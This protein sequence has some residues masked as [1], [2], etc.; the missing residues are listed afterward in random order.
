MYVERTSKTRRNCVILLGSL[1][2]LQAVQ[3]QAVAQVSN[4]LPPATPVAP[5]PVLSV[6]PNTGGST[7]DQLRATKSDSLELQFASG[8]SCRTGGGDTPSLVLYGDSGS[9]VAPIT[10]IAGTRAGAALVIPLY[11][12]KRDVCNKSLELHNAASVL[13]LAEKMV[14]SG[15]MTNEEYMKLSRRIKESVL[16][17]R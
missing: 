10:G 8:F 12:P 9:L 11:R 1:Q 2:I 4:T 13:E 3:Y 16:G 6:S 7:L 15:A 5:V 17:L 14:T